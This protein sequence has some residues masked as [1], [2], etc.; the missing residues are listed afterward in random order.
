MEYVAVAARVL[1]G[2][3]LLTSVAGKVRGRAAFRRFA[4]TIPAFGL[5]PG[6]WTPVAAV[7]T[8]TAEAVVPVLLAVPTTV[9]AGQALAATLFAVLTLAVWRAVRARTGAVCRCFGAA[10]TPLTRR[11][12]VRN[13]ILLAAAGAG[14]GAAVLG[15]GPTPLGGVLVASTAGLVGALCVVRY[16]DLVDLFAHP[17]RPGTDHGASALGDRG[18]RRH[19]T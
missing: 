17:P 3:V 5:V 4:A 9:V 1:V 12:V 19:R 6:R 8:V 14:L 2:L 13:L 7:A 15:D 18:T 16:E 11:H 10:D